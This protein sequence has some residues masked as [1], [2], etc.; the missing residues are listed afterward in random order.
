MP[1]L[2][3]PIGNEMVDLNVVMDDAQAFVQVS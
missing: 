2:S 3:F 1:E